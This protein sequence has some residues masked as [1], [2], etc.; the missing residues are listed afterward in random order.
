MGI[1]SV[2]PQPSIWEIDIAQMFFEGVRDWALDAIVPHAEDWHRSKVPSDE[3]FRALAVDIGATLI[4]LPEEFTE[5]PSDG[6]F[7]E[8]VQKCVLGRVLGWASLDAA[9]ETGGHWPFVHHVLTNGRPDQVESVVNDL[10]E[11]VRG[12]WCLT[13]PDSGSYPLDNGTRAVRVDGGWTLNGNRT[14]I[15]G[16]ASAKWMVINAITSPDRMTAFLTRSDPENRPEGLSVSKPFT[17]IGVPGSETITVE[18]TDLFL[19]DDCVLGEVDKALADVKVHLLAGRLYIASIGLG[20]LDRLCEEL[21]DWLVTNPRK[22]RGNDIATFDEV[23]ERWENV[24]QARAT[25]ARMISEAT[26][27]DL[28]TAEGVLAATEAKIFATDAVQRCAVD[29]VNILAGSGTM[30]EYWASRIHA[31]AHAIV[32]TEGANATLRASTGRLRAKLQV[33]RGEDAGMVDDMLR[34]WSS[35]HIVPKAEEMHLDHVDSAWLFEKLAGEL[36]VT[37][38]GFPEKYTGFEPPEPAD[39]SIQKCVMG[40]V[41]GWASPDVAMETAGHW[42]FVNHFLAKAT[43]EQMDEVLPAL[44][45]GTRGAWCLTGTE[46]G[47][48]PVDNGTRAVRDEE[49]GGWVL[50]GN[51]TFIT[52]GRSA[53]WIIVNA[54]TAEGRM[55]AFLAHR[56]DEGFS[57]SEP[58]VKVG[59]PGS[60]TVEVQCTDLFVSNDHVLGYPHEAL[61][62]IKHNLVPGRC[63]IASIGLGMLDRLCDEVANWLETR[64]SKGRLISGF[65]EVQERWLRMRNTRDRAAQMISDALKLDPHS[66]EAVLVATEAKIFATDGA[67]QAAID[68]QNILGGS[69][70]MIEYWCS[71]IGTA[72]HAFVAGEGANGTLRVLVGR[73]RQK[74][75]AA[76]AELV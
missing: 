73:L 14:F 52:G 68:A 38:T 53:E 56:D 75:E 20:A 6:P 30:A 67:Q 66:L 76:R 41:V 39:A 63:Y 18:C 61:D 46:S 54:I 70:T 49:R 64:K 65:A 55:T 23:A 31:S 15:T 11:G 33:W 4:G 71:R 32:S 62:D 7:I 58:F 10:V 59:V 16:G 45:E 37:L 21:E 3:Y 74:V 2:Q 72:A 12:A 25:A 27:L 60:E 51:R 69:G 29:A 42:L 47:S 8:N 5:I 17:K 50:N 36:G 40:R 22:S 1:L 44:A 28:L 35:E 13:G 26:Y 24:K 43:P 48:Y 19:P 34:G 9:V 57:T